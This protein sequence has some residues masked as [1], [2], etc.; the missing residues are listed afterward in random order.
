LAG[1]WRS[2]CKCGGDQ[3]VNAP[4]GLVDQTNSIE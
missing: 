4:K 1:R 2:L 3:H